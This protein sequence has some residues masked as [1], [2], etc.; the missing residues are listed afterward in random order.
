M[1]QQILKLQDPEFLAD[2]APTLARLRAKGPLVKTKIPL[3]GEV[4]LTTTDDAARELLKDQSRFRRDLRI[5]SKSNSRKPYWWMPN[6]MIPLM[7]NMVLKDGADH[8]RLRRLV[9]QAFARTAIDD[10]KPRITEI[11]DRLLDKIDR[12]K[13]VDIV[14]AYTREL[15]FEVICELLG[16]PKAH[17]EFVAKGIKPISSA[18]RPINMI[19]AM[20]RLKAILGYFRADFAEVRAKGRD[21]LIGELVRAEA[22]GQKLTDDELLAMVFTLFFAG[23][24]TTVHLINNA[25][26]AMIDAPEIRQHLIDNPENLPLAIEEFMRFFSPVMMTKA[27]YAIDD[28][29]FQGVHVEKGDALSAFLLAANHDPARS[30]DPEAQIPNRRPNAHIGFGFGPHVCLGMQLARAEA[31]IALRRLFERFPQ[32]QL[33]IP[34]KAVPFTRRIGIR[35]PKGLRLILA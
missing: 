20:F 13:P 23:H 5:K 27:H 11:A 7:D 17:R 9:D 24:E 6:T 21:G 25:I 12:D 2:P 34:G 15:P 16:I 35:A 26:L 3:L 18:S 29:E 30:V 8:K 14:A 10:L 1:S 28:C 32:L 22:E 19:W 31:E 33:E 4:W